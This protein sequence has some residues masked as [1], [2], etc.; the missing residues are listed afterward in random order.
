MHGDVERVATYA[1]WGEHLKLLIGDASYDF[2]DRTYAPPRRERD[3]D[4]GGVRSPVSGVLVA[5]DA[6]V[7]DRVRRGQPLA[8]V[9]AMKMQYVILAPIDGIIAS[10]FS[11]A[12]A[13]IAARAVLF[14]IED[15]GNR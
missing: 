12:G 10:A 2:I 11:S 9:E 15:S 3:E 13:Q 8:T 5:L 6:Q 7:G 1:R 14:E 4:G